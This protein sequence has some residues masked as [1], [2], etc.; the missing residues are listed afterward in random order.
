MWN[1]FM[2]LH[3]LM[4]RD[5]EEFNGMENFVYSCFESDDVSFLPVGRFL[6][7]QNE[8]TVDVPVQI[9]QEVEAL[10]RSMQ[11]QLEKLQKQQDAVVNHIRWKETLEHLPRDLPSR[12]LPPPFT[13]EQ[14]LHQ[15][16]SQIGRSS[17]TE[18]G[19]SEAANESDQDETPYEHT[20]P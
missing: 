6:A 17:S 7:R 2:Y 15:A 16:V 3:R 1:Y 4:L 18:S 10:R 9:L 19:A 13:V 14:T 12:L 5:Q 8:E 11:E 20:A